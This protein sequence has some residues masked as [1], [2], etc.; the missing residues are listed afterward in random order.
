MPAVT[1][2]SFGV[3]ADRALLIDTESRAEESLYMEE[4]IACHGKP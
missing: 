3:G 4:L 2:Q 1:R